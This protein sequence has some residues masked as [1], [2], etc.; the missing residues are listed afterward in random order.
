[1]GK[2]QSLRKSKERTKKKTK[3]EKKLNNITIMKSV[4]EKTSASFETLKGH[5]GYTNKMQAPKLEKVIVSCGV[6][7]AER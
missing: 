3:A 6:G 7:S 1:M 2:P 4:K 5:F